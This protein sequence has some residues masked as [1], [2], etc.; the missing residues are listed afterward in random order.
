MYFTHIYCVQA[1]FFKISFILQRVRAST[2][3]SRG[4]GRESPKQTPHWAQ[5]PMCDSVSQPWDRDL[6]WSQES[7]IQAKSG[8]SGHPS[9]PI[10]CTKLESISGSRKPQGE[11]QKMPSIGV[12]W[13]QSVHAHKLHEG[14]CSAVTE[15]P[16]PPATTDTPARRQSKTRIWPSLAHQISLAYLLYQLHGPRPGPEPNC[17]D[18]H[19]GL[20]T[21]FH[22]SSLSLFFKLASLVRNQQSIK[23]ILIGSPVML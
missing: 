12:K 2:W 20:L 14:R 17:P 16:D 11:G 8:H 7:D 4:K 6:G 19:N 21:I 18:Y 15:L 22:A 1:S 9:A 23:A 13:D 5:S 3:A 10:V